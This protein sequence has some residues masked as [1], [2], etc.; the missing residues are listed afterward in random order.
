I[1]HPHEIEGLARLNLARAT[2]KAISE[3]KLEM[4]RSL[5]HSAQIAFVL[6]L[7]AS[8]AFDSGIP[9]AGRDRAAA[10]F[11]RLT[12]VA[13]TELAPPFGVI[14]IPP[15]NAEVAAGSSG[16]GWALD[17]SGIAEIHVATEL[18]PGAPGIVG[19]ARPD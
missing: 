8:R 7:T 17:D 9:P 5:A 18:G 6:R 14:D 13:E 12:T 10:D 16:L 15:E 1:F 19:R 4:L 11:E 2:R 3:G